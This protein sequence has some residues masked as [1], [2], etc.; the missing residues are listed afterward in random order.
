MFEQVHRL[1][2]AAINAA[3]DIQDTLFDAFGTAMIATLISVFVLW[4]LYRFLLVRFLGGNF[5]IFG[6]FGSDGVRRN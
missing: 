3:F 5:G 2:L 1:V 6:S 4:S